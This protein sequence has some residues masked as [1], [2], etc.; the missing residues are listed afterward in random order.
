MTETLTI[1]GLATGAGLTAYYRHHLQLRRLARQRLAA[2]VHESTPVAPP[3]L[4]RPFVERHR[5]MPWLLGIALAAGVALVPQ[6]NLL[7][8]VAFG[9]ILALMLDQF[10]QFRVDRRQLL[11]ESQLADA[12]DMMV[13]SLRAGAS[14]LIALES[15][16]DESLVPLQPQLAEVLGRIR[17]GDNP[18]TALAGLSRRVRLETFD[19][20]VSALTV[21]WEVGGS[22]ASTLASVGKAVRERIELARLVRSMTAQSRL[23]TTASLA[24]TYFIG[25]IIWRAD[26]ERM[27]AFLR[28]SMG[29]TLA[30]LAM[31]LQAVGVVWAARMSR[32]KV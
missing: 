8:A 1:L 20:F 24:L 6:W 4:T 7:F 17:F 23:S 10:D 14:V 26:P 15:A 11:I 27:E 18:E 12:I 31:L 5:V 21:Q 19:L 22:L 25:L 28:T 16:A 9:L 13:G 32:I 29:S 30:A 3:A 2:G